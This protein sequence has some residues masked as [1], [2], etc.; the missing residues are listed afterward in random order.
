MSAWIYQLRIAY[1]CSMQECPAKST[2]GSGVICWFVLSVALLKRMK[3]WSRKS[4]CKC[5]FNDNTWTTSGNSK[6]HEQ[7][8]KHGHCFSFALQAL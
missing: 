7:R 4:L 3:R 5:A 2:E 1:V 6:Q 8:R